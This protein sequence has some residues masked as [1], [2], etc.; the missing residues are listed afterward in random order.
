MFIPSIVFIRLTKKVNRNMQTESSLSI[1]EE[2]VV[3]LC[4]YSTE[5][6]DPGYISDKR[7]N[8]W[9]EYTCDTAISEGKLNMIICRV[10]FVCLSEVMWWD[11]KVQLQD[12][13]I[14]SNKKKLQSPQEAKTVFFFFFFATFFHFRCLKIP[15]HSYAT[16]GRRHTVFKLCLPAQSL[17]HGVNVQLMILQP[18]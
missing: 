14:S 9:P 11:F 18:L 2:R 17:V 4:L 1:W 6:W 3:V 8:A 12:C 16:S 7:I 13:A 5:A 10:Y 15:C